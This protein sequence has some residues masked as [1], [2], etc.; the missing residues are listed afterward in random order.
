MCCPVTSEVPL[1]CGKKIR[2]FRVKA[3]L[4]CS[5]EFL[6]NGAEKTGCVLARR[7]AMSMG[8]DTYKKDAYE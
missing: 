7:T 2:D 1:R 4:Q 8:D 5:P 3:Q 6:S